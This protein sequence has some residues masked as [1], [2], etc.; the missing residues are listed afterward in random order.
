M[1]PWGF[2]RGNQHTDIAVDGSLIVNDID[3]LLR[4][5]LDGGG[6]AGLLIP[7]PMAASHVVARPARQPCWTTGARTKPG[8]FLYHPSRRQTPMPLEVFLRFVEA[9]RKQPPRAAAA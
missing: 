2:T 5:V 7:E 3:L 9:W 6:K 8:I 4:I 1:H